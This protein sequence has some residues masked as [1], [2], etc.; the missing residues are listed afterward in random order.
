MAKVAI[1][2]GIA[3]QVEALLRKSSEMHAHACPRQ[4]LGIRMGILA[5]RLLGI[6]IPQADKRLLAIAETDGCAADGVSVATNCWV[7]RRTLRI[8]D[9][10]KI[11]ATFVDTHTERALRIAPRNESRRL[12]LDIAGGEGSRFDRYLTG[13]MVLPDEA[14]FLVQPV[15]LLTPVKTIISKMSKRATCAKCGEEINNEREVIAGGITLCRHCAGP[16]YYSVLPDN[17]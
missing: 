15:E 7:G 10:G 8:E 5:G 6:S 11:A 17:A 4:V 9:Y 1:P 13:Y 2:E 12:A 16:S 14:L 3:P